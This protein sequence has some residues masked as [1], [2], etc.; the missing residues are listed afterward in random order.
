MTKQELIKRAIPYFEKADI[1]VMLATE[2]GNFFYK[3]DRHFAFGHVSG[4]NMK[5]ITITRED[6]EEKPEKSETVEVNG[7]EYNLEGLKA[8][9][10]EEGIKYVK[11]IGLEKLAL[12]YQKETDKTEGLQEEKTDEGAEDLEGKSEESEE[13]EKEKV[14][15]KTII[16][17]LKNA[18]K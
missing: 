8:V 13:T 9:C 4:T 11:N 16:E 5:V 7:I 3:E 1:N 2:D 17:K 12:K 6:L 14:K 18:V 15:P 10:D